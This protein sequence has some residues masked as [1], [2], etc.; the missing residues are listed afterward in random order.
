MQPITRAATLQDLPLLLQF[1]QAIIEFERPFDPTLKEKD[2]SYYDLQALIQSTTAE[3]LVVELEGTL[4]ASGY[5][6]VEKSNDYLK[7]QQYAYMGF[8][9]VAPEHRGQ[10]LNKVIMDGLV[11]WG[12]EKGISEFR[13]EV[14]DGNN[15]A[16]RAYEKVGF[17]KHLIE[18]RFGLE[19]E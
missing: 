18:M 3:V 12:K 7:H 11:A 13:L 14:Y 6:K 10:G 19:G 2:T 4:I 16:I 5:A 8:M 17:N 9:Y 1:E 15:G